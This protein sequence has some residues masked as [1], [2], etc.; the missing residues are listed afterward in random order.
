MDLFGIFK[1]RSTA[2]R[3]RI[4]T[5]HDVVAFFQ[6]ATKDA[7]LAAFL[8]DVLDHTGRHGY[9]EVRR[10]GSGMPYAA[11]YQPCPSDDRSQADI[12]A[13]LSNLQESLR[14]AISDDERDRIERQIAQLVGGVCTVWINTMLSAD[15]EERSRLVGDSFR[16]FKEAIKG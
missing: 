2:D 16:K 1:R 10:G 5:K 6:E 12:Q 4:R 9:I 11:E 14:T 8:T 7:D 13:E 15:F 3:S